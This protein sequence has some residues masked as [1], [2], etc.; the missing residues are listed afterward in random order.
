LV[1][2]SRTGFEDFEEAGSKR[3]LLRLWLLTPRYR[4]IPPFFRPRFEDMDY[5]LKNPV[6]RAAS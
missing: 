4:D 1:L 3:H 2:H 6:P 5:W